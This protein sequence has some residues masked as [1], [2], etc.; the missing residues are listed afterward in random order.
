M[1]KHAAGFLFMTNW[2]LYIAT[3]LIWGSTWFAIE[4]Q[5]GVVAP[6]ISLAWRYLIAAALLFAWCLC[7]RIPLRFDRRSH[8]YFLALGAFLFGLNYIA[9]YS[10][11]QYISSALNCV[12]FSVIVW[13][14]ILN[15]RLF[16]SIRIARST[17]GGALLGAAG[18]ITLF[19][20]EIEQFRLSDTVLLGASLSLTGAVIASFGNLLS[21][22][23][24]RLQHLPIVQTN[25]WGM[26]YGGILCIG[27]GL[28]RGQP[29]AFDPA[30]GYV[31][32]L[33][34]LAVFGSVL[35][36]GAY[37]KLLGRIGAERAGY[38]MLMF[39]VVALFLSVS[40]E[41]LALT[42]NIWLGAGLVLGGN[43]LVLGGMTRSTR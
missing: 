1:R 4:F 2:L 22:Q 15:A 16:L 17:I 24:Q 3:V 41:G 35:A 39:P 13:L 37:L 18:I 25:A 33:L 6:E 27:L 11:Q 43:L 21:V 8:G 32:S 29:L 26:L 12:A 40:F 23:A 38:S 36:F 34:Y 19:W 14:N 20:P 10:A 30:P 5:L 9:V 28:L 31:L 7:W 42:A